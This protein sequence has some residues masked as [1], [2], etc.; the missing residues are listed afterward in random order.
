MAT[1]IYGMGRTLLGS[2]LSVSLVTGLAAAAPW[3]DHDLE[4][5]LPQHVENPGGLLSAWCEVHPDGME[6]DR[7][8]VRL[9]DPE[10]ATVW[11]WSSTTA[12]EYTLEWV[13]PSGLDDGLYRYEVEAFS[14]DGDLVASV[15]EPFLIAG[16]TNGICVFKFEDL[17]GN[18][19][20]ELGEEPLLPGW[21]FCNDDL[22]CEVTDED[23]VACWF[24]VDEGSYE[25][26]ETL[27]DGWVSTTGICQT[28]DLVAGDIAKAMF[29][30][31]MESTP[32]ESS[33]WS[34]IKRLY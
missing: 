16:L 14:V 34:R 23:G 11:G 4:P 25:I 10:G 18:G 8:E 22:G 24:F 31:Q 9:V 33:T 32:T 1:M 12:L 19:E 15:D 20:F 29:G 30:N 26:C 28:V 27:Q 3:V 17:N 21:E 5:P 6:M 2:A 13:V 7:L